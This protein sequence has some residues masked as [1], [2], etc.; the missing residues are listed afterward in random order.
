LRYKPDL[1]TK[2]TCVPVFVSVKSF[3]DTS[4]G[5]YR[6]RCLLQENGSEKENKTII[7]VETKRR[8]VEITGNIRHDGFVVRSMIICHGDI[9]L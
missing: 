9:I 6:L 1:G 7:F 4:V 3:N 2:N 8:V 5:G